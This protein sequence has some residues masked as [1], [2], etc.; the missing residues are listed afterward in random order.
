MTSGD[1]TSAHV[2]FGDFRSSM[3]NGPYENKMAGKG[4]IISERANRK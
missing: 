4:Q 2:T 3:R 1:V